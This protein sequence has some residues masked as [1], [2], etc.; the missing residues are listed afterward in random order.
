MA[1]VVRPNKKLNGD[2]DEG[3]FNISGAAAPEIGIIKQF[4]FSSSVARYKSS[5]NT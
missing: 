1:T 3:D 2:T 5:D 4:P